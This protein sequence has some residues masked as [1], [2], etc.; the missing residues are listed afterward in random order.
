MLAVLKLGA[1]PDESEPTKRPRTATMKSI[2]QMQNNLQQIT[3][4]D[5][6]PRLSE[7]S[8]IDIEDRQ[9][10]F[11]LRNVARHKLSSSNMENKKTNLHRD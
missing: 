8:D 5:R 9:F 10:A 3:E 1:E 4:D 11:S 7:Q 6:E 2:Q